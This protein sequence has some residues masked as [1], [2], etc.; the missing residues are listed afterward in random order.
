VVNGR[1][2]SGGVY[3]GRRSKLA[4]AADVVTPAVCSNYLQMLPFRG[5]GQSW[6]YLKKEVLSNRH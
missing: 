1:Q 3:R 4:R 6:S 2:K 5:L